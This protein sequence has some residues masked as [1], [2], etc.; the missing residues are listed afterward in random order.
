MRLFHSSLGRF[1]EQDR[2]AFLSCQENAQ[3]LGHSAKFGY[4]SGYRLVL[5][6]ILLYFCLPGVD[7]CL[8]IGL[9]AASRTE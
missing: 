4:G 6:L 3:L 8:N 5:L 7:E 1:A 9:A 2:G